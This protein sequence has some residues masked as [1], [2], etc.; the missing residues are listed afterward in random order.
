MDGGADALFEHS[1]DAADGERGVVMH[2]GDLRLDGEVV[3]RCYPLY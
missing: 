2:V 1:L 3:V